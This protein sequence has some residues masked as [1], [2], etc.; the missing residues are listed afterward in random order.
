MYRPAHFREDRPDVLARAIAEIQFAC[1][2]TAAEG[3]YVA[4]HL[5]MILKNEASGSLVLE[6]HVARANEHWTLAADGPVTSLAVFQG[7]QA[8]VSPS[9]YPSKREHGK[10][11]PTWAYIAVHAH[12]GLEA[13]DDPS[14]LA[15]HL[16]DLTAA[17]EHHRP[18]PWA[19]TDAPATFVTRLSRAI[20]GLRL[21]VDR[22]E[23]SWK[24]LQNRTEADRLG[25]ID[26]LSAS[27]RP[28]DH[29]VADVIRELPG[30]PAGDR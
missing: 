29:A 30:R 8:Y 21:R 20:V 26:G 1:L 5:P 3:R 18:A 11:V 12:G 10:V 19:V 23:G 13:V 2:I 16:H 14:R 27:A 9:W 4:T 28:A 7:P 17:N 6:G 22:L 24:M 15:A 25:A